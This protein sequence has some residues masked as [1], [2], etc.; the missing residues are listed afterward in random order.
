MLPVRYAVVI[1]AFQPSFAL[2]EVVRALSEKSVPAIVVIDDGS[3]RAYNSVFGRIA[4]LPGVYLQRHE[5]NCGKGAALKTGIRFAR[6]SFPFLVGIVTADADGQHHPDDIEH[7]MAMQAA[8]SGSLVLGVRVFDQAVPLRSRIGN[9]LTRD[10]V[11]WL[12]G[13]YLSDTQTGLR[14]IPGDLLARLLQLDSNAYEFELEMLL[15]AHRLRFPIL[16]VPIR[17]IYEN[18]NSCSHFRPIADS[19]KIGLILVRFGMASLF[20]GAPSKR[21]HALPT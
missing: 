4:S 19:A 21:E 6:E 17:T 12:L 7:V 10:V 2:V 1:P 13:R 3:G 9:V 5:R 11:R 18:G 16:E 15:A 8:N 20:T 14:G